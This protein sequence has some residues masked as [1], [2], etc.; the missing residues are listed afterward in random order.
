MLPTRVFCVGSVDSVLHY[1]VP[2]HNEQASYIALSRC[3]G[4]KTILQTMSAALRNFTTKRR[5]DLVPPTLPMLSSWQE[6]CASNPVRT[7][8]FA[9][10]YSKVPQKIGPSCWVYREHV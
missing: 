6:N 9:A 5:F 3:W 8:R 2:E 10:H 7:G 1:H 4:G